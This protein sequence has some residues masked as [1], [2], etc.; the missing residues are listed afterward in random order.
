MNEAKLLIVG[1]PGAGKTTLSRKL[2]NE[3]A[4]LPRDEDTTRGIDIS[5]FNF[6]GNSEKD[7]FVNIWD[8]GGQEIYH[9]THQFFLTKRS[10]YLLVADT[11]K[12]DT[13][14]NY[15]LQILELLS[16]DSPIIIVHN[17]KQDRSREINIG[18]IKQ[19]FPNVKAEIQRV[20][21]ATKRGLKDLIN[22]IKFHIQK[23]N[24]VGD[25]LPKT[26]VRV[27]RE[28]ERIRLEKD[29]IS[30]KE[31]YDISEFNGISDFEK[32]HQLSNYLH[33]LGVFLHFK[34]GSILEKTIILNNSW[35]T[36]AVY[37]ILDN[38]HIKKNNKGVF[39]KSDIVNIWSDKMYERKQK[40]IL[41]LML[42]FEL[43]YQVEPNK[44]SF[45]LPQLLPVSQPEFNWNYDDSIKLRYS[46]GF[47]PEGILSKFIVR[48]HRYIYMKS[49]V[50]REGV[51]LKRFS[52]NA[53]II[54][55][56]GEKEIQIFVEGPE[57]RLFLTLITE[58]FDRINNSY[59]HINVEKLI[60]CNCEECSK[61][62]RPNYYEYEDLQ[63]RKLR[64]KNTVECKISYENIQVSSLIDNVLSSFKVKKQPIRN[65]IELPN[66]AKQ[67]TQLSV[68]ALKEKLIELF[69][70]D[71]IEECFKTMESYGIS[72]IEFLSIQNQWN[73]YQKLKRSGKI[74]IEAS[75]AQNRIKNSLIQIINEI[76]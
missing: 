60:P 42:K 33:D 65:S 32:A 76:E 44:D 73:S 71:N 47:M 67:D 41:A 75:E 9:S 3:D 6:I 5:R 38:E 21:F 13:S 54:E 31:F 4:P 70:K 25:K 46:Y 49:M 61:L 57:P 51:I 12:E 26:W 18:A 74:R 11:R 20:N 2:I 10:L 35:A 62:K 30:D 64:S 63:R 27:R 24:H 40:E 72:S 7:F 28:L 53:L 52:N 15:W 48:M 66:D 50:W 23:L 34:D 1:E 19:R 14:Y 55:T 59:K 37:K 68:E 39:K 8:F 58:E 36:D 45:I 22:T 43:I 16:G 17:E 69:K 56:Y 29:Y